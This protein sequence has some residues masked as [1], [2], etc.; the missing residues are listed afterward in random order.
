MVTD[1][2]ILQSHS[3]PIKIFGIGYWKPGY[4]VLTL[5]D[6]KRQYFTIIVKRNEEFKIGSIYPN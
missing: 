6:G 1:P 3:Q 4:M 2:S 5:M